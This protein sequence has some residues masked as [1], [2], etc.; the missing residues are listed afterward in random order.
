MGIVI[1]FAVIS[2]L[3]IGSFGKFDRNTIIETNLANLRNKE[4]MTKGSGYLSKYLDEIFQRFLTPVALLTPS[5]DAAEKIAK[6]LR[7]EQQ[8]PDVAKLISTVNT[9]H[10]FVPDNQEEKIAILKDIERILPKRLLHR[11]PL[12]EQQRVQT[13]L[14]PESM[15]SFTQRDLPHLILDRFTEKDHSVGKLVLV[16]PPLAST[17]WSGQEL[18]EFV[19]ILRTTGDE[20]AQQRVPVAGGL[21]V[22]SDMIEAIT[23]DGP[24]ATIFAFLSVVV[25]IIV[26]FR[27]PSIVALTLFALVLGNLWLFGFILGTGFKINFL[28]FIALPITFGI[29]IDYGVN[30]FHRYLHEPKKDILKVIRETG[31]AV[32]LCSLTTITGYCSLIIARNQAFVSFGILAVIGEVTSLFAAVI[33]LPALII[34]L[35]QRRQRNTGEV[36]VA[37][38]ATLSYSGK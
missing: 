17:N 30:V 16:E 5:E 22:V 31:G 3:S 28:N 8:Q 29:G 25:L 35:Q 12:A 7:I 23:Q 14:R 1:F 19:R 4:S 13:F 27:K 24:K 18:N 21:P 34:V 15:H 32:A 9:I 11:L 36:D 38:E 26:L 33:A 10:Q 20:V 6:K 2:V 37:R